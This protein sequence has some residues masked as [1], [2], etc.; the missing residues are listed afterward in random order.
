MKNLSQSATL[1]TIKNTLTE[2]SFSIQCAPDKC[3]IL[4]QVLEEKE[5]EIALLIEENRQLAER[6]EQLTGTK[7]LYSHMLFGRSSEKISQTEATALPENSTENPA[8]PP[9]EAQTV[10]LTTLHRNRIFPGTTYDLSP[11]I[12]KESAALS[13]DTRDTA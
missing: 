7:N 10:P 9:N 1:H 12:Q 11:N 2:S 4:H 13:R 8:V 3:P 5:K 6:L